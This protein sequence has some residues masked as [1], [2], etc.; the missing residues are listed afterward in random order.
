MQYTRNPPLEE[1]AVPPQPLA[2]FGDWLQA[3]RDAGMIEP[4]AFTLATVGADGRP[5]A[6]VVL[7]KGLHEDGLT[8]YTC[9][10]GRKGRELE[11]RPFAA[12]TFWWDRLERQVRFEGAVQRVPR[13]VSARYFASRPRGSQLGALTSRQSEVVA[14]RAELDARL[15]QN[16]ARLA[17][18]PVPL[19]EDW[20]G[21]VLRPDRVEFWQ[22]RGGRLHDRLRYRRDAAGW[23]LERLEP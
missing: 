6:R 22:G 11:A 3:A 23:V 2:L 13:E 9:Y 15:A 19:P 18:Q 12:A 10:A 14:T 17:G 7:F 20:G 5:S 1:S 4:T 21:Y 16:E 8:F